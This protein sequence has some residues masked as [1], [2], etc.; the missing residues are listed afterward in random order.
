MYPFIVGAEE[1]EGVVRGW[2]PG[3]AGWR[4]RVSIKTAWRSGRASS[5]W[6]EG[7]V[8]GFEIRRGSERERSSERSCLWMEGWRESSQA[9]Y[10]SVMPEVS[11]PAAT[12]Y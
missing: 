3:R 2:E 9:I 12:K 8:D 10:V 5:S 1:E 7:R 4:R 11:K 6:D